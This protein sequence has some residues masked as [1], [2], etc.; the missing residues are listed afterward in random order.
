MSAQKLA[1]IDPQLLKDLIFMAKERKN[2]TEVCNPPQDPYLKSA[3]ENEAKMES[4]LESSS[5][6][7][8][9]KV[10]L[11]NQALDRFMIM[12]EKQKE[13]GV[14]HSIQQEEEQ[15]EEKTRDL[16][17]DFDST[18]WKYQRTS[19]SLFK[20][21]KDNGMTVNQLGEV[22]LKGTPIAGSNYKDLIEEF[23]GLR[24]NPRDVVGVKQLMNFFETENLDKKFIKS[25]AI[26]SEFNIGTKSSEIKRKRTE[27]L[28]ETEEEPDDEITFKQ[29]GKGLKWFHL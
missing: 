19:K 6:S 29:V 26:Q 7:D 22:V 10:Q 21:L 18:K 5:M 15:E 16:L 27:D 13:A 25:P 23:G 12:N 1:L 28:Q 3:C 20:Y 8:D 14:P 17:K 11:Y 9:K 24:T 2:I 4:V